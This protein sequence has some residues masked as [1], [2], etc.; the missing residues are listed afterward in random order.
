MSL[1]LDLSKRRAEGESHQRQEVVC[2]SWEKAGGRRASR[3]ICWLV[4]PSQRDKAVELKVKKQQRGFPLALSQRTGARARRELKAG[5]Q[6]QSL[7]ADFSRA[8][9]QDP[10]KL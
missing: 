2:G 5:E 6:W 7:P 8:R 9:E 4:S 1:G 3:G 10:E